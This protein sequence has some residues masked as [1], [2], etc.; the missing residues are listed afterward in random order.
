MIPMVANILLVEDDRVTSLLTSKVIERFGYGVIVASNGDSAIKLALNNDN[1]NLVL[2]DI[3]LGLGIDGTETARLILESK[4]IPIIFLTSHNEKDYVD[5]VKNITNYGYIIKNSGTYVLE[6]FIRMA[7]SL[8]E[9]SKKK[10]AAEREASEQYKKLL[11]ADKELKVVNK[12][13]T[14]TIESLKQSEELFSK[15]FMGNSD[16]IAV[17]RMSD[18]MFISV[19]DGF[20]KISGYTKEE[21]IGKTSLEINIWKN[22]EDR[23]KIV[24]ELKLKGISRNY[25]AYYL[26]KT[27]EIYGSMSTSIIILH[28]VQHILSVTKDITE[29]HKLKVEAQLNLAKIEEINEDLKITSGELISTNEELSAMN[30]ELKTTSEEIEII[31]EELIASNI[32]IETEISNR[33]QIEDEYQIV[34]NGTATPMFLVQVIDNNIFRY[35]KTNSEHQLVTGFSQDQIRGKTPQELLGKELGD[36]ISQNYSKC[37]NSQKSISYEEI[38]TF[39]TG[40][41][42]WCTTLTPICQNNKKYIIGSGTDISNLKYYEDTILQSEYK[43]RFIID[44]SYSIIYTLN[45]DGM[46]TFVSPIWTKLLGHPI[47]DVVGYSF[48]LFVHPDD[49][50]ECEKYLKE[51][52][53]SNSNIDTTI[54]YRCM[55][56]DGSWKWHITRGGSLR[57][58]FGNVIGMIGVAN[59]F[60]IRKQTEQKI[61]NLLEEKEILI[62]EIHHRMKNNMSIIRGLLVLQQETLTD[63]V[64]INALKDA[65]TRVMSMQILYDK[66]YNSVST[67]YISTKEYF[68][69]LIDQIIQTFP[70]YSMI[71]VNNNIDDFIISVK[72]ISY[73]GI[74]INEILTN[75]MKYAFISRSK[76]IISITISIHQDDQNIT[77]IIQDDGVGIQPLLEINEYQG[78][79]LKLVAMMVDQINGNISIDNQNGTAFTIIFP[80]KL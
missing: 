51:I 65:E 62:K 14:Y 33:N 1:I 26:T 69:N 20:T 4:D 66:L 63:P 31:N 3:D 78:F 49:V 56:V 32:Q 46:F 75:S 21:V 6:S 38:L 11:I 71:T 80:N 72:I 23:D 68:P 35:D 40:K 60:T 28:N 18:G 19:N 59:D 61:Q 5:K 37:W 54:E 73:V 64:A 47:E 7:L 15:A 10:T 13:L 9:T 77:L 29:V 48:K 24:E 22:P 58:Q 74:I 16:S 44:N 39:G 8:F 50:K 41:K 42:T 17:T 53:E 30:E 70:N 34:F 57:D 67:E 36:Q 43:Y 55:H 25:E 52:L 45:L 79:G 76:G 2:M 12:E 27:G